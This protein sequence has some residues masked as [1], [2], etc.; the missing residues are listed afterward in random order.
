MSQFRHPCYRPGNIWAH[1]QVMR[2]EKPWDHEA[3]VQKFFELK[4]KMEADDNGMA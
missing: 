2:L 1:R 4:M 3:L